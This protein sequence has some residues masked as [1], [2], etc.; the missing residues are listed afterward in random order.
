MTKVFSEAETS[1]LDQLLNK[2]SYHTH[3]LSSRLISSEFELNCSVLVQNCPVQYRCDEIETVFK[4]T[5]M[6]SKLQ[7]YNAVL[8]LVLHPKIQ[9]L[10]LFQT[11]VNI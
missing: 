9:P 11:N 1:V 2:H 10:S 3:T 8:I 6:N 5:N 4:D 7:Q